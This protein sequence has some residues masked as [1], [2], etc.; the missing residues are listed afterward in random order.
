MQDENGPQSYSGGYYALL[1]VV[2]T[3]IGLWLFGVLGALAGAFLVDAFHKLQGGN[4]LAAEIRQAAKELR[5]RI[6]ERQHGAQ[7]G[8]ATSTNT[9]G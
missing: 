1:L 2:G 6:Q 5:S 7:A 3:S 4:K 9:L 8:E